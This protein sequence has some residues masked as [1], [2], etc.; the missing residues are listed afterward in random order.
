MPKKVRILVIGLGNMGLSHA[1]AYRQI[2]GFEIVGIMSRSIKSKQLPPG[3]E[4]YPRYEDL[5][6]ALEQT[7][8]DA[9]SINSWPN[10]HASYAIK[11]I[12]AGCHVF[13]EKPIA[14]TI[15]DAERVVA[16]AKTHDRKL[17]LG[18]IL[19]VHPSWIR[20]IDIGRS[21]GKPLVM[22]LNLNQQSSGQAWYWHKN[23]I[24]S[25]IPI[26]DCGVHYVDV[27]CQLTAA[28]PVR[29]HGI[30]AKLWAEAAQDNYGHL[31]VTFDDGSVGWYEAG[32]G[33]MMS[34]TAYF[35]KDVIGPKG[36]VSIVA[37]RDGGESAM[38]DTISESADLD[39]HTQTAT[40]RIHHAD[41]D[42]SRNFARRD[43]VL[44]MDDEPGHQE[45]C[46]REQEYFLRSIHENL[47][48]SQSM[49]AAVDSLRIVLAA[50]RSIKEGRVVELT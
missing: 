7:R 36:S 5:D 18:Y 14:T 13:M 29:V 32:W 48:L 34:E 38:L 33:P 28:K 35:V 39:R 31:H 16:A 25:L 3:Y 41:V 4:I 22:R 47:D 49:A 11:A 40:I 45:L 9:V 17:V 1:E 46:R 30:G 8:P 43:D 19:R 26:V 20:F 15:E 27:M 21:L 10:T 2:D 44:L 24:D 6:E 12:E 42:E 50:E 23:L 37:G